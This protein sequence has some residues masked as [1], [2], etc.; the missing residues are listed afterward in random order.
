MKIHH[1]SPVLA[2]LAPVTLLV[3]CSSAPAEPAARDQAATNPHADHALAEHSPM[4]VPFV[5]GLAKPTTV[6]DGSEVELTA[7]LEITHDLRD[8][9]VIAIK[10]PKGASL[11]DGQARE[12]L[13]KPV[14][15]KLAR[16][17]RVKLAGPPDAAD[18]VLVV[19]DLKPT[20]D[21]YG[22]H[23]A[24]RWPTDSL[25]AVP[26]TR[27]VPPPPVGLPPPPRS[28]YR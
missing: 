5:L 7:T 16:S 11:L 2:L 4:Q 15:G 21:A 8:P 20:H 23:A 1:V 14:R 17:Y 10:L 19:A 12:Q 27:A 13:D 18:P 3:A 24:R 25:A 22:A 6:G 28:P 26:R 9:V